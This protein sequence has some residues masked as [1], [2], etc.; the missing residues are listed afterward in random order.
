MGLN[1]RIGFMGGGKMAEALIKLFR[2]QLSPWDRYCMEHPDQSYPA[3]VNP[4]AFGLPVVMP[5]LGA[6]FA[7]LGVAAKS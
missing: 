7:T 2:I 6:G 4:A 1:E 3:A 5:D